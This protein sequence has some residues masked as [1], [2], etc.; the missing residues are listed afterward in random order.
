MHLPSFLIG[1]LA[2]LLWAAL[3]M[4]VTLARYVASDLDGFR[5]WLDRDVL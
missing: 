3:L 4:L 1:L 5:R 2:G